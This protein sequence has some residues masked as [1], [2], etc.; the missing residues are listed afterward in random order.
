MW[1]VKYDALEMTA[2]VNLKHTN[3]RYGDDVPWLTKSFKITTF[4]RLSLRT[5][6]CFKLQT[7]FTMSV[8]TARHPDSHL[9]LSLPIEIDLISIFGESLS[10]T[11]YFF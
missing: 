4:G 11:G 3:D 10:L 6:N 5:F 2:N 9:C 8:A 7:Y 1:Q